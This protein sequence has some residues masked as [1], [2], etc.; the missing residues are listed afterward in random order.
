MR[1]KHLA[2]GLPTEL[3]MDGVESGKV[4]NTINSVPKAFICDF[5]TASE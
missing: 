3:K 2:R 4:S 5:I 1:Y